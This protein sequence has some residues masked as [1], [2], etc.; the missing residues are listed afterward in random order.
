MRNWNTI[1]F[2]PRPFSELCCTLPMRNWNNHSLK[3]KYSFFER[4]TLPMRNWN[5]NLLFRDIFRILLYL[6]YEEL[7]PVNITPSTGVIGLRCTL[8]MRNWNALLHIRWLLR[9]RCTLPMRNWNYCW[10]T[11]VIRFNFVVPYLWGIET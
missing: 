10:L 7:K 5:D 6:T 9:S 3:I 11:T 1:K 8:P 2:K 4:C